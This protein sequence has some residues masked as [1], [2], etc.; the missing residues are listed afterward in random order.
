MSVWTYFDNSWDFRNF[1]EKGEFAPTLKI[2]IIDTRE[3]KPKQVKT[4]GTQTED[5]SELKVV[6]KGTNLIHS[7]Q[8][9]DKNDNK[10]IENIYEINYENEAVKK[11]IGYQGSYVK[12]FEKKY[13]VKISFRTND[14]SKRENEF[15]K[16]LIK[17]RLVIVSETFHRNNYIKDIIDKEMYV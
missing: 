17:N 2:K 7:E 10:L 3:N 11:F 8:K 9:K 1:N 13:D 16:N 6:Y 12:L 14:P 4:Q 5:I 15:N